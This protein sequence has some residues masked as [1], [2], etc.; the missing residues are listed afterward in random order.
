MGRISKPN[1]DKVQQ[2]AVER[3]VNVLGKNTIPERTSC[4]RGICGLIEPEGL[5]AQVGK[6]ED[7]GAYDE[8]EEHLQPHF[9]VHAI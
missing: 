7:R 1:N 6:A 3:G 2:R 8:E 9:R 5:T 4:E